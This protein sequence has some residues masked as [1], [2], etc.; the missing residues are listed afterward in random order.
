MAD[1]LRAREP[2]KQLLFDARRRL[3]K[4]Y[5]DL[6]IRRKLLFILYIQ[7]AIPLILI[8]YV[9]YRSSEEIIKN[10]S[11]GYSQDILHMIELRLKDYA[12]N[13]T[14]ISQDLLYDKKIYG[15]LNTDSLDQDPLRN[16]EDENE[17][18][19]T[20]KKVVLSRSEIQS[21]CIVSNNK[22]NF[23][24]S[25]NNSKKVSIKD[26]LQY[27]GILRKAR[28]GEGKVVWYLDVRDRR[29]NNIF[30][31]RTVYNQD[32]FK[33][34]GLL[35]VLINKSFL[36]TIY[37][38]LMN[39]DMQNIAVV[40]A[41]NEQIISRNPGNTYLFDKDLKQAIKGDKGW[42]ID[43][44]SGALVSYVSMKNPDWKV[45]SYVSLKQLYREIVGLRQRIILLSIISILILSILSVLIG[46]DF[47]NPINK[48]V[49]GME[50][51][52]KGESNISVEVDRKDELGFLGKTFK[53]QWGRFSID[54]Y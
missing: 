3:L 25:D 40:S 20:L 24:F 12:N 21:I 29:V 38:D 34:I 8:G 19:N 26:V 13:L 48:L 37:Q 49:K 1:W 32:N 33:E 9:S 50:I 47:I 10:K 31:A 27:D 42:W 22:R 39:D 5:K 16:Y 15:I 28:E 43:K 52:Q 18:S 44:K 54:S 46:F 6:P 51:V 14:V 11:I 41:E 4:F 35:A 36:E 17:I 7:I 30:L 2:H 53:S 23:Y 45:V